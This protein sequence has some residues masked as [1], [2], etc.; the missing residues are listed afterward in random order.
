M[1]L[2]R[3]FYRILISYLCINT[4]YTALPFIMMHAT[5]VP[6]YAP[7]ISSL[8]TYWLIKMT[9]FHMLVDLILMIAEIRSGMKQN[10]GTRFLGFPLIV[11]AMNFSFNL[12]WTFAGEFFSVQ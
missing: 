1:K 5:T 4:I 7:V 3:V 6:F 10:G 11:I 2:R 12:I 8:I 9:F